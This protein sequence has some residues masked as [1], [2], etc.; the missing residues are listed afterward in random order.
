MVLQI[1][2]EGLVL[3]VLLV[4]V[5]VVG[6]RKSPVDMV[7]LYPPKVRERCVKLGLTTPE[8]IKRDRVI[9]K[10]TCIPG[11]I[12]Y[13]LVC[14]YAIN[15]ARGFL[16][17]FWQ[18]AAILFIMGLIDR[19]FIDEYWVGRTDAWV[20]PGTEDLK[21]YI[22]ARDKCKKWLLSTV[23]VVFLAAVLSGIATLF[24]R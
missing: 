3:G 15:G 23:W 16:A 1:V 5:C 4:L 11:Y 22:R 14:V 13:V 17:G 9:F 18:I 21:P 24:T 12:I 8:R 19:F 6:I 7:Y 10:A 2:L 20:I